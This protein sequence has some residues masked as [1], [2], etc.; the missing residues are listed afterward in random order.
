MA[1]DLFSNDLRTLFHASFQCF[2]E[3]EAENMCAGI[4]ERNLCARLANI[5]ELKAHESGLP[6]EYKADVEYNRK[7][8]GEIKTIID[9]NLKIIKIT[10]D[11][12]LHSRG[13]MGEEDNLIAIEMKKKER[14]K[15]EGVSDR[16]RLALMTRK[17]FDNIWSWNGTSPEHVCGYRYGYYIEFDI[18]NMMCKITEFTNGGKNKKTSY[19]I[20]LN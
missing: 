18:K 11:I 20:Q 13:K 17:S 1:T 6:K 16:Q 4:S 15:S 2:L 7:Q 8:G 5:L 14:P 12:I 19:K 9:D 3:T 10:C